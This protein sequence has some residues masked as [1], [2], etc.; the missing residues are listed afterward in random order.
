MT[1]DVD[2][3]LDAFLAV[4]NELFDTLDG[5]LTDCGDEFVNAVPNGVPGINSVYALAI[6]I[7]GAIG[8]WGGSFV[9]G[10]NIPRDRDAEFRATGTV[11][12][13]RAPL[14]HTRSQLLNWAKIARTEGIRNRA[15]AGTT[16]RDTDT[17]SPEFVLTHILRELAQHVGHAQIC[18]DVVL[19]AGA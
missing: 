14:A 6:H 9:S 4:S 17:V 18:R 19:A 8:F 16:R 3:V 13:A 7:A 10:E 1:S 2:P 12:E 11:A 15:A 5:V